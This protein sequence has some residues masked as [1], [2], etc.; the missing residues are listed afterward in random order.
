MSKIDIA[1]IPKED[2]ATINEVT[3][4]MKTAKEK[5]KELRQD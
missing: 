5:K 4:Q 1:A 3:A 2:M